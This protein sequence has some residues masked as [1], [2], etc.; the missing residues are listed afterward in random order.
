[1]NTADNFKNIRETTSIKAWHDRARALTRVRKEFE[2]LFW[3]TTDGNNKPGNKDY[4][5]EIIFQLQD[6][7][8]ILEK[9]T[10]NELSRKKD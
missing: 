10:S 8:N 4:L 3:Q 9:L 5:C 1:M 6:I 2:T 7:K